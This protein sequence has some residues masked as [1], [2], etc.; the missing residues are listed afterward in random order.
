MTQE[1]KVV[2]FAMYVPDRVCGGKIV[3]GD[4][5]GGRVSLECLRGGLFANVTVLELKPLKKRKVKRV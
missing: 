1:L 3:C 4:G 5:G 2:T